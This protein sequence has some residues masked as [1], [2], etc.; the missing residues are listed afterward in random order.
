MS[1]FGKITNF[2]IFWGNSRR[3][4]FTQVFQGMLDG[5]PLA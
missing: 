3:E 2:R 1:L 4:E 5:K